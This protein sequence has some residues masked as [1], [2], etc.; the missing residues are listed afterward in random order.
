MKKT[1][2]ARITA[3]LCFY[4]SLL[5]FFPALKPWQSA[6]A[7]FAAASFIAALIAVRCPHAVLRLLLALLPGLCFLLAPLKPLLFFPALGWLYL[8]LVLTAGRFLLWL[9]E[10][11]RSFRVMLIV[12]LCA[13]AANLAHSAVYKGEMVSYPGLLF[14]L[15]FF[16]LGMYSLRAMQMNAQMDLKWRLANSAA[17]VGVPVLAIGGSLL[18]YLLLRLIAP[19]VSFIFRPVGLFVLWFFDKLFPD[20][21][22]PPLAT[23]RPEATPL[24][25]PPILEIDPAAEGRAVVEDIP[26]HFFRSQQLIERATAIGGYV[27]L[28]ILLLLAILLVVRYSRRNRTAGAPEDFLYEETEDAAP[29]GRKK[30]AAAVPAAGSAQQIRRIYRHYLELMHASGVPIGKDST[31]Q[32]VQDE[33]EQISLSPAAR[34]LRELYL[35][36]RYGDENAVTREDVQ[37]ARRCLREI[38]DEETWKK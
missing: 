34:R 35:K 4:F 36:A 16:C 2:P 17:V 5:C 22:E 37:E 3:D 11:R 8:I 12:C 25:T 23:L 29:Q 14:A 38:R 27:V 9:D 28:G 15:A 18:L 1:A 33:A 32:D 13:V 31:S 26:D 7:L 24:P 20:G 6:M 30:A 10:Y 19:V 21:W